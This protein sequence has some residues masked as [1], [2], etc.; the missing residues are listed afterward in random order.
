MTATLTLG[1]QL[2]DLME[3]MDAA[4]AAWRAA[5]HP[6]AGPTVDAKEQV[7]ADLRAFNARAAQ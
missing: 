3:R 5:G 7:Y 6:G 4:Y 2:D 1:E